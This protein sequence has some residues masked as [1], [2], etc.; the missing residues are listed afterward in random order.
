MKKLPFVL[1]IPLL[2]CSIVGYG[3]SVTTY[4]LGDGSTFENTGTQWDP[5]TTTTS[6]DG[7]L[8]TQAATSQW[9]ST[10]YGI[11]F[12]DTNALEI[13][14]AGHA[15]IRF[16]GSVYSAGTMHGGTTIGGSDLGSID[17]DLD[18]HPG[19]A[20][21]T[22]YYE[23]MYV[24]GETTLYFTFSGSNAY[25][26]AIEVISPTT[27]YNLGDGSTFENTG[28]QW[29]PVTTT[30]SPDG[31]LR[32]QAA[33]SQWHSTGYGIA[34]KDGNSLEIDVDGTFTTIRFYG[35]IYSAGTMSGGTSMGGSDLGTIDVD[36]DNHPGMADRT[37]YY[38]FTYIGG[39][40][41]LYFTFSGSNAYTPAIDVTNLSVSVAKTD[42]WDFGA[43]QL[44]EVLYNNML[45]EDKINA[46]YPGITPGT[47][48]VNTPMTFTEGILT[49]T[50]TSST[51]DRLRTS[52]T[53]LT[54]WDENLSGVTDPEYTGRLYSNSRSSSR[55]FTLSL[56][57]D[58]EVTVMMLT[59]D[60][61]VD[62]VQFQY[63]ADPGIQ[64]DVIFV[65][66][67]LTEV[68]F[69][70]K[71]TGDY[72]L[73][74]S[75]DKISVYRIYRKDAEYVTLSGNV[76]ETNAPG[77][78]AGYSINFTN[79][80]GKTFSTVVSGGTYSI[81]LPIDYTY[82]LSLSDAN[83][84]LIGNGLTL[85]V[86]AETTNYDI[87]VLQVTLFTVT[88]NITGLPD[89]ST[90]E[91]TY[92]PDP[93]AN[94]IYDPII[95][96]DQGASTYSVELEANVE[97]TITA[98]GVNDYE[99]ASNTITITGDQ[100]A[101][102]DF[103]PK[104]TYTITINTPD[105][106][107]TQ[108][109]LVGLTF[110]NLNEE[111]YAY[112][113][114]DIDAI[115]LRDGVYAIT[116]DGGLD[117]YP[118]KMALTSNLTVSG[119][120]TAKDLEFNPVTEWV[121]N[122]RTISSATAYE[123]LLFTGNV[124]VRGGNGDLLANSGATI[125]IPVKPG[126][127]VVLT[128]YYQSNYSIE[129]GAPI[130]NTSNSTSVNVVGEYVYPGTTEGYVNVSIGGTTYFVSIKVLDIVAYKAII[131][132]GTD[133][134]YQTINGALSAI[135]K[136]DRP[137]NELVTV[138][139]DPGNYEEMLVVESPNIYF[140]N[141]G[142]FPSI[143]LLNKG[144]D[145]EEGAV[146][147]TSYYGQKYNFFSQGTDNKWSAE[148]LAVNSANGYTD[149]V[150]REGTG[151]G[152]SYWNATVVIKSTDITFEDIILENSFNQYISLKES[153]DVVL[154]KD[155][156]SEPT[157]PT[158]YGNTD[159]QDRSGGYVTQAAAI[160]I[161]A[162]ADKVILNNC[163]VIGRQDS[164]YGAAPARVVVYKGAM[165]GAV[166]YIYGAMTAVFY[167]TD[168]VL[169]TSDSSNDAAYITAAQQSGGRGYLMY[170]CHV[171]SPIPGVETASTNGSKP[172]YFGRPWA[173]NTSEVVFYNTT[174]DSSTY[175]G[176]EGLSLINPV[177]WTSSLGGESP[178]MYEYGS[179][180]ESGED[181]SA[182]R[183][184]W[185]T[186]LTSPV[187]TDGTEITTFNFTKGTDGW[188]PIPILNAE[189]DSD[190]DGVLD[191][192]D[193]CPFTPNSDQ[194]D[195]DNDGIGDACEDSDGDGLLDSED[196]CPESSPGVTIDVFG[197]EVF[198]LPSNNFLISTTSVTCNGEND[199][200]ISISAQDDSYAYQVSVNGG[201]AVS[202]SSEIL[203]DGL[204]PGVYSVCITVEGHDNYEQCYNITVYGP[205][206][207]SAF[208]KINRDKNTVS[209]TLAGA[210]SYHI[211]HNGTITTT[212]ESAIEIDLIPG[213]NSISVSTDN[214]CQGKYSENIFV[215]EDVMVFPNPT[216]GNI[217]VYVNGKDGQ[218]EVSIFDLQG[219]VYKNSTNRVTSNRII[220]LDLTSLSNG[221]Y[222]LQLNGSTIN[223]SIKI[224]K[225]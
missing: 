91:L 86:T 201:A 78:P 137:N 100:T 6:P 155:P 213:N 21:R 115:T 109:S 8:R 164:F 124:R 37:G 73:F 198:E 166:D 98:E 41:T 101:D 49:W 180:E 76:D 35:S 38:E 36:L 160:G 65:G 219:R 24:G 181:H 55:Y 50:S 185:S 9:H 211:N 134:D 206:P 162:S 99:I 85:N 123:G 116:Y 209:L 210:D 176:S 135:S 172:G 153:Q 199:G 103:T 223:K 118:L 5:V 133:K 222:Y 154:A 68:T 83:G 58:D 26:P 92:T 59:Q 182:N 173:P 75:N 3:Q 15:T 22:G 136:M 142:S 104:P 112:S 90:L 127:K 138:M 129:G 212:N 146:R 149:Y 216:R 194:A 39:P 67:D 147:I 195:F 64:D 34:F 97:Y 171:K 224:V 74:S 225:K 82:T 28:T 120:D 88:G 14:V 70:A 80:A 157:R 32:T 215:S 114:T 30:T 96:I 117:A 130:S 190:Y 11:A 108:R 187:L 52:N 184:S 178:F 174:I 13:D 19:M 25:T 110:T 175:P 20:D 214:S 143:G 220:D 7:K 119:A 47:S 177:G 128:D 218:V 202:F 12:K 89:L 165:M 105:L 189:E 151:S 53:N 57:E 186:V 148:V 183:V 144:V 48:G 95:T 125:A 221:I 200:S 42:V 139:I 10:G 152:D 16:Y 126:Q 69:A 161:A 2:I 208:T 158:D 179:M 192:S 188:D 163:R 23:F 203:L 131:T 168:F 197:C 29:D 169:N 145:I 56:S 87:Q 217:Q 93:A 46:W 61:A 122:T 51:S 63:A 204:A 84:Y 27:K 170:E 31:K 17:V 107:A 140:K 196:D 132:V 207:L 54:R 62:N 94:K 141:A 72:N 159:V 60:G 106:D 33:T 121:F 205:E 167:Q 79:Q 18:N 43:K 81:D 193:I 156:T 191:V 66:T 77:I 113:F 45:T 44:D 111:G 102:I 71:T 40:T 150:N 1:L 4:N